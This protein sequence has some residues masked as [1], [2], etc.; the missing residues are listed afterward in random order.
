MRFLI[1]AAIFLSAPD[2]AEARGFPEAGALPTCVDRRGQPMAVNNEEVIRWKESS[3]NQYRN[4]ALV[5]GSLVRI[6]LD[7]RTHL[8]LEVDLSPVSPDGDRADHIEIIYNKKFGRLDEFSPGQDVVACG[9]YITAREQA[10]PYRPS[11]VGAVVHWVHSSYNERKHP[12]GFL[13]IDGK[14]FGRELRRLF[15]LF[16]QLPEF[17]R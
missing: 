15:P 4:R 11:P 13:A 14:V 16:F 5:Q 17:A 10:G 3:P 7:R 9:V 2:W 1:F 8:H 6:L 12:S